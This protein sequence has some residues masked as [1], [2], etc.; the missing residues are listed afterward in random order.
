MGQE[1]IA[2][3]LRASQPR[4]EMMARQLVASVEGLYR[5]GRDEAERQAAAALALART[6]GARRFEAQTLGVRAM[7]EVRA[8]ELEQRAPAR[9]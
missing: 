6:L 4:A 2:L 9:R 1:A 3:A 8:G 5:G 7:L